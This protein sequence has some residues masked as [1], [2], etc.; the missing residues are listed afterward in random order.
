MWIG[1]VEVRVEA[2]FK[3][4]NDDVL[5]PWT[6]ETWNNKAKTRNGCKTNLLSQKNYFRLH[7][8]LQNNGTK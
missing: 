7:G 3:D 1:E 8:A 2:A 4:A 5:W 6:P